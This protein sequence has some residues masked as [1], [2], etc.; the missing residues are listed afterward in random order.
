MEILFPDAGIQFLWCS[1]NW[2][3]QQFFS[4]SWLIAMALRR[5]FCKRTWLYFLLHTDWKT[6]EDRLVLPKKSKHSQCYATANWSKISIASFISFIVA[7]VVW[8]STF[9][10]VGRSIASFCRIFAMCCHVHR[11][12]R[13]AISHS[14]AKVDH[15]KLFTTAQTSVL[16]GINGRAINAPWKSFI[17]L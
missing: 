14:C 7:V 5:S 11:A 8:F 1:M 13:S 9:L 15:T 4:S 17:I 10:S 3:W 2:Q 6:S 12:L 16:H